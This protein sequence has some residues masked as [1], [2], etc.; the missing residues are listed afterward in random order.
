MRSYHDSF[1]FTIF[2]C[3]PGLIIYLFDLIFRFANGKECIFKLT[4]FLSSLS[5]FMFEV[6]I[7][8]YPY[9]RLWEF[10]NNAVQFVSFG[11]WEA[12]YSQ[13]FNVSGTIT[14]VL[15]H[16]PINSTWI[17]SPEFQYAQNLIIWAIL[18]K[19]VVLVFS[20]MAIKISCMKNPVVEMQ[21]YCY[22][23]AA[24]VLCVSSLFTFV[25]VSW[26]HFADHYDQT[27]LKF[28]PEFPVKKEA[29]IRKHYTAVFPLAVLTATMSLFGVIIFLS[30][31]SSLKLQS[32]VKA[33]CASKFTKQEV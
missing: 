21:I 15:V 18:M 31:I 28:P 27:I 19:P 33:K 11:L 6:V 14:K 12:Q 20:A 5:A 16:T 10:N 25:S 23:F 3:V 29:L 9:W 8:S 2:L 30:E 1:C 4:G 22:K 24:L 7:A 26:N 13:E 17:I 32:Q